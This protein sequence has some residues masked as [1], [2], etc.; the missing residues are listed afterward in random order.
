MLTSG[1]VDGCA[2]RRGERNRCCLTFQ[3]AVSF[4]EDQG[5]LH[6]ERHG[7]CETDLMRFP[8]RETVGAWLA[9]A[10]FRRITQQE[11]ERILDPKYGR[12]VFNDPFLQRN[13][14]SQLALLTDKGYKAGLARIEAD[15]V[16]AEA[17]GETLV[18]ATDI[19]ML[20]LTGR[21]TSQ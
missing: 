16:K 12:D 5:L 9:E 3:E 14:C 7:A 19:L 13:S 15:L 1:V 8:A 10:G 20:M 4:L 18:F 11:V 2:G 21:K 6:C 17:R